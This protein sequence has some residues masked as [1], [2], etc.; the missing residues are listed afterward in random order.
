MKNYYL[1]TAI[2]LLLLLGTVATA[3]AYDFVVNGIYYSYNG[4]STSE[5]VYVTYKDENYNSYSGNVTIPSTVTYNGRTYT[6]DYI[7][8]RAFKDCTNLKSV[9]LP[10]TIKGISAY[11]FKGCTALTSI[12][13]PNSVL[14][15]QGEAFSGCTSLRTVTFGTD[16]NCKLNSIARLAFDGCTALETTSAKIYSRGTNPP[17]IYANTFTE[18]T[19]SKALLRVTNYSGY[20][21]AD[22]W[23]DFSR[24][25][26]VGIYYFKVNGFYYDLT[27]MN[28]T[29][30]AAVTN[31][32]GNY[33]SYTG[34]LTI[35]STVEFDGTTYDV[36][37]INTDAFR[38]CTGLTSI[39]IPNSVSNIGTYV[40]YG[41]TAL[42][43]VKIGS[44][45]RCKLT[46]IGNYCFYGCTAL[47][48]SD[49]SG[50]ITCMASTPPTVYDNTFGELISNG[51]Q[52]RSDIERY[53]KLTVP[54]SSLNAYNTSDSRW[55]WF[56]ASKIP[57]WEFY[58]SPYYYIIS[59]DN[60]AY[61]THNG[62][63][64][65]NPVATY[66]NSSITSR[67]LPSSVTFDGKTYTINGI[68]GAFY[69]CTSLTNV[70]IPSTYTF[71]GRQAFDGCTG[72][73]ENGITIHEG[74]TVIDY[75]AFFNTGFTKVVIPS[76]VTDLGIG[77][78]AKS[79]TSPI[80]EV[81]CLATTPPY[82]Y[83]VINKKGQLNSWGEY[84][85]WNSETYD[86][87][88]L[89]VPK[90][91]QS[92]YEEA[93]DWRDFTHIY[94][95][96]YDF[97]VNGIYYKITG[98]NTVEV[99]RKVTL[100]SIQSYSGNIS[101]PATVTYNGTTYSVTAIGENAFYNCTG[102]TSVSIPNTITTI[103][104]WA[105][106]GATGITSFGITNSVNSIED[107]AFFGCT[108]LKSITIPNSVT[109]LGI[110]VFYG[111]TSLELV[112]VG[113][114]ITALGER[115]FYR[116]SSLKNLTFMATTPPSLGSTDVFPNNA[117][118]TAMLFV[119]KASVSAYKAATTWK[120]FNIILP[121]LNYALDA[122]DAGLQFTTTT[123]YPWTNVSTTGRVYAQSSNAGV[124]GSISSMSLEVT[125]GGQ[126]SITFDFKAWGEGTSTI[127]DACK[128]LI[129][130][131]AQFTYGA[132][133]NDWETYTATIPAGT[134]TLTWSYT[135]DGSANKDGDY[136][137]VD[138]VVLSLPTVEPGD[139]NGD[140]DVT[141]GDVS[142]LID[143]LMADGP[144]PPGADVNGDGDVTIADV[145]ALIDYLLGN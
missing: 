99:T 24:I 96:A 81:T 140:G 76:T 107:Y 1:R 15:I 131:V 128:F 22:Y 87:A 114:G 94:E 41:C 126:G 20:K 122:N 68:L 7:F 37:S 39:T 55:K 43:T 33:N 110:R 44:D 111:C 30:V 98:T 56:S 119:P 53:A 46:S 109:S 83:E 63:N 58:S 54:Y 90:G 60:T 61:I 133:Q 62:A 118:N 91:C 28:G 113:S 32:D 137:A 40:F 65:N 31:N 103:K 69:G 141:I 79:G 67:S 97:C 144:Y 104:R 78:F 9:T 34:A 64:V 102:V 100:S 77:A 57:R 21:A 132:R 138:N 14:S 13:I 74:I 36:K 4:S 93:Y 134:H 42:K 95:M 59:G 71:L 120:S 121:T 92:A 80:T 16:I 26:N 27:Y 12:T 142:G 66:N 135:K 38:G 105:F 19:K 48:N 130:G 18:N 86:D 3:G 112:T 108:G 115:D 72:L 47:A 116:C 35:P 45:I 17:T 125:S 23:K 136:F 5:T 51:F 75:K 88:Y 127:F 123:N 6:V 101:I 85:V 145:S 89:F 73:N 49:G 84:D 106:D 52:S 50:S 11:A 2:L 143:L 82:V 129:D 139:V 10:N 8:Q 124:H 25:S 70:T 117:F 29:R